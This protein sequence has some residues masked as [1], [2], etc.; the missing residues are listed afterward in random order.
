[1]FAAGFRVFFLCSGLTAAI[2]ILSWIL[3]FTVAIP[4]PSGW[5]P[6]LWHAHELSS[7]FL[8][9]ALAG[10]LLTA[11]PSWTGKTPLRG[12][13]LMGLAGLWL[14]GR[15]A[16]VLAGLLP[17]VLVA[18][19][20]LA[21]LPV[22]ILTIAPPLYASANRNRVLVLPITALWISA[23]FFHIELIR[24]DVPMALNAIKAG[25]NILLV[26]VTVIGGRIVP[27]FTQGS[28]ACMQRVS[29][30]RARHASIVL[31]SF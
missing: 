16:V 28:S 13:P 1:L 30:M 17:K 20:D 11:V 3:G 8:T 18:A 4:L 14:A 6:T 2:A 25:L 12:L 21:F 31:S 24:N 29:Y 5:A 19:V 7:G 9:A 22:L 27:A 10:F 15:I 26:L 23:V